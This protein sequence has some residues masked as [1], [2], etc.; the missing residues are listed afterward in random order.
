MLPNPSC[1]VADMYCS[2]RPRITKDLCDNHYDRLRRHGDP[3]GGRTPPGAPFAFLEMAVAYE[4]DECLIW[5]YS[6]GGPGRKSGGGYGTIWIDKECLGA[7]REALRRAKGDPPDEGLDAC[8]DPI[9]CTS[10]RCI[11]P[12]H[13]RWDTREGNMGDTEVAGT[14]VFGDQSHA[15][16]LTRDQVRKIFVDKRQYPEIAAEYGIHKLHV[17]RIKRRER[18]RYDTADLEE[19]GR[20]Q[21]AR[22]P[23]EKSKLIQRKPGWDSK[24]VSR[25]AR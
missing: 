21:G 23:G 1:A 10:S 13:L 12:N 24:A 25:S 17:G 8:H 14:R 6:L 11:N 4:G 3:Q 7:H 18:R 16:T 20:S 5:P 2:P 15:A 22:G 19:P 9:R